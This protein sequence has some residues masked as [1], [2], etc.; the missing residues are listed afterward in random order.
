MGEAHH[1]RVAATE[2]RIEDGDA[3]AA[4]AARRHV[5][6]PQAG[7]PSAATEAARAA[8]AEPVLPAGVAAFVRLVSLVPAGSWPVTLQVGI[9]ERLE[10]LLPPKHHKALADEGAVRWSV[11]GEPLELVSAEHRAHALRR[12]GRQDD[13]SA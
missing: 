3:F 12:L 1:R 11:T 8:K 4:G 7:T 6:R 13:A 9:R 5:V 2:G 10:A